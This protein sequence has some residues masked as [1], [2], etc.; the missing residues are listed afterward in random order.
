MEYIWIKSAV[1]KHMKEQHPTEEQKKLLANIK[2]QY[3]SKK[4]KTKY[5]RNE[6]ELGCA[7]NKDRVELICKVCD[8]G[9]FYVNKRV[10]EHKRKYYGWEG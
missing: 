8:L 6:H 9:G 4:F 5:N 3:C 1:K 2:C 7:R 10:L